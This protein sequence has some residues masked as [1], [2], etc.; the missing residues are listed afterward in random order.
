MAAVFDVAEKHGARQQ[1]INL[2]ATVSFFFEV[3][4]SSFVWV[5]WWYLQVVELLSCFDRNWVGVFNV[6]NF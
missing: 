3:E 2:I 4:H 1:L 6:C 5:F